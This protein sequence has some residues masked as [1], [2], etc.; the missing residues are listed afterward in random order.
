MDTN[1]IIVYLGCILFLFIIGKFFLL[2]I[3][4][5]LKIIGNSL[6]GGLLIFIVNLIGNLFQFHIGL[7]A[8]TAL[9][10]GILGIPGA[11]LL[12]LLKIFIG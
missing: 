9:V 6:L 4:F 7:N 8:I 12:I 10:T 11:I 1:T 5:I 3:K 2:P